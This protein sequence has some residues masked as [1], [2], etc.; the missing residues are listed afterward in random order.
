MQ[1]FKPQTS[2]LKGKLS[3]LEV[4][5]DFSNPD[6][7]LYKKQLS[8]AVRGPQP[9]SPISADTKRKWGT[10]FTNRFKIRKGSGLDGTTL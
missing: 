3:G 9:A 4:Q 10:K 7:V 2:T 6:K 8:Q 5:Q 1:T